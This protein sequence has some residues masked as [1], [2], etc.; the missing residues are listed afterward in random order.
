VVALAADP[1][2]NVYAAVLASEASFIDL[3]PPPARKP[4]GEQGEGEATVTVEVAADGAEAASGSRPPG[5]KGPRA[6]LLRIPPAGVVETLW[7][8]EEET[9]FSLLWH[10]DRLWVGTGLEGKLYSLAADS[11]VLESDVDERQI[12]ALLPDAPGL[13]FVSTNASALYRSTAGARRSGTYTSQVLDAGQVARWG[14]FHWRGD[15][16]D[17]AAARFAFRSGLSSEPDATWSPWSTARQGPELGLAALPPGRYFQWRA[18]LEA[19]GGRSP[20][21]TGVEVS[22]RQEN[23]RPRI[24]SFT[25]MEPGQILVPANFNPTNQVYEPVSPDR[26]GMFTVLEGAQEQDESRYKTLWKK[27]FRT[28]RWKA[29]DANGDQLEYSLWFRKDEDESW[30]RVADEL[31]QDFYSFDSTALPDGAYRFR[32][33]ASD[34]LANQEHGG[35]VAE[36]VSEA[37]LVDHSAPAVH[38][39]RRDGG[40]L[41]IEARDRLNPLREAQVSVDAGE[42]KQVE[43]GDGLLDGRRE[44]LLVEAPADARLVLLRLLDAAFNV[45]TVDL[46][47]APG[48]ATASDSGAAAAGEA[49][50]EGPR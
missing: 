48:A 3:A 7:T 33:V 46:L 42:W 30:L 39:V 12:V 47:R 2:G 37:V 9:V 36:Q 21:I 19:P 29:A 4:E 41:V 44:T 34:H 27:G 24:S 13:S 40:R 35:L 11:L 14:N 15:V 18:A 20:R 6:A 5:A 45:S 17:G 31:E 25:A 1:E 38:S 49:R 23:L 32:L 8:F 50:A 28:L 10:R 22:Y 43:V 16:P 26:E